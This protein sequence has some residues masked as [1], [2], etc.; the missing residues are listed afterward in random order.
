MRTT[1]FA[2]PMSN[3]FFRIVALAYT[4]HV[5]SKRHVTTELR[6][7]EMIRRYPSIALTA[8]RAPKARRGSTI[9]S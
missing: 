4:E 6:R 9:T 3:P 5:G 8:A 2:P 1:V 7:G